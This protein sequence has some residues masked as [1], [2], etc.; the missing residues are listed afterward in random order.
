MGDY[1]GGALVVS[2]EKDGK[3]LNG[4][5]NPGRYNGNGMPIIKNSGER[6]IS[7]R[8]LFEEVD[9][10]RART[11]ISGSSVRY[12]IFVRRRYQAFG[13]LRLS[14]PRLCWKVMAALE[15]TSCAWHGLHLCSGSVELTSSQLRRA[16]D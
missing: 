4:S 15:I 13:C 10:K 8:R 14:C 2:P 11:L 1:G 16:A 9:A 12:L 7:V 3:D 6:V 5:H